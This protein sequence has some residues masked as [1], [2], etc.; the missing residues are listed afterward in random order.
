MFVADLESKAWEQ[1]GKV[2]GID[3]AAIERFGLLNWQIVI[4][5]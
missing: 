5:R 3:L 1:N 2:F 4:L